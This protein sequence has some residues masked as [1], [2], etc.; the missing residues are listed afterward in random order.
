M[1]FLHRFQRTKTQ[2]PA[3]YS[4]V[5]IGRETVKAIVILVIPDNL[6]PQI[7]G[8]G[9]AETGGHDMP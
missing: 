2:K 4:L 3:A 9:L 1:K 5:D 6:E 7:I 8:Y